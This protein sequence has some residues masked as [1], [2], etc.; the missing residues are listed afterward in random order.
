MGGDLVR[1]FADLGGDAGDA[2]GG[3]GRKFKPIKSSS[4]CRGSRVVMWE[5]LENHKPAP[6]LKLILLALLGE[7]K[8]PDFDH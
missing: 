8:V 3:R 1:S 6:I 4:T 2:G 7:T 5:K